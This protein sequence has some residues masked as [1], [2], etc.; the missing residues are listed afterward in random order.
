[1]NVKCITALCFLLGVIPAHALLTEVEENIL[2]GEVMVQ[3][4]EY[5]NSTLTAVEVRRMLDEK[6]KERNRKVKEVI[7]IA[8]DSPLPA[9]LFLDAIQDG[10]VVPDLLEAESGNLAKWKKAR[11]PPR[12]LA[13]PWGNIFGFAIL[14]LIAVVVGIIHR[15]RSKI[16]KEVKKIT[17]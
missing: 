17:I 5:R 11:R 15:G 3:K 13:I 16:Q 1:M 7:R 10:V 12:E 9:G 14:L 6:R 2:S 4:N 8:K